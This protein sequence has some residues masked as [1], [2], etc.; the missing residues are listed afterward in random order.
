M[1][2]V[3]SILQRHIGKKE[4]F[5]FFPIE[6]NRTDYAE[7]YRYG[8]EYAQMYIL[9]PS[10]MFVIFLV[11]GIFQSASIQDTRDYCDLLLLIGIILAG[12]RHL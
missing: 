6:T 5:L 10:R 1:F 12:L 7:I 3:F 9:I 11:R 2:F 4:D 8:T